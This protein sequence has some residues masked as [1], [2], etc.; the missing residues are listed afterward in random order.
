MPGRQLLAGLG[1]AVNLCRHEPIDALK[2][3]QC[4]T[5]R[6]PMANCAVSRLH[7]KQARFVREPACFTWALHAPELIILRDWKE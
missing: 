5:T 6:C 1:A 2:P 3:R 4:Q 7:N